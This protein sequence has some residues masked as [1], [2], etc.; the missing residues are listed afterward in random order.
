MSP[1]AT[2]LD[3]IDQGARQVIAI[4]AVNALSLPALRELQAHVVELDKH[5]PRTDV[6][7]CLAIAAAGAHLERAIR[8]AAAGQ[9]RVPAPD[10]QQ[11]PTP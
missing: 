3:Q 11:E 1:L 7:T 5:T 8:A 2:S 6:P 4:V 10:F 9:P